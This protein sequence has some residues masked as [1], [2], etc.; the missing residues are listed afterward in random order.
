MLILY[1]DIIHIYYLCIKLHAIY[2]MQCIMWIHVA[3]IHITCMHVFIT[4][5]M[6]HVLNIGIFGKL[7]SAKGH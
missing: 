3:C 4:Y 7:L 6:S 2:Y 5:N 1:F